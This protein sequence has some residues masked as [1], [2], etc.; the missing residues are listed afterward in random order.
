MGSSSVV[1]LHTHAFFEFKLYPFAPLCFPLFVMLSNSTAWLRVVT[2]Q[3]STQCFYSLLGVQ[4]D[5]DPDTIKSAYYRLAKL[6]H[7]D[8]QQDPAKS[9]DFSL[10]TEAYS[11]LMDEEK[12]YEYDLKKGYL[13]AMDV[14]RM[15]ECRTR[16]GSRYGIA[17]LVTK[18]LLKAAVN[19]D[20]ALADEVA[21]DPYFAPKA[22][23]GL[24][25]RRKP[26]TGGKEDEGKLLDD[27]RIFRQATI[28]CLGLGFAVTYNATVYVIERHVYPTSSLQAS[29]DLHRNSDRPSQ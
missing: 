29:S 26:R 13:N 3:F 10:F 19:L 4:R 24:F 22:L 5:A 6:H 11:T 8:Q 25:R 18:D 7:P 23:F 2:R 17:Y 12:R 27:V 20:K 21:K 16:Y 15:E 1:S 9:A 14:D 28:L